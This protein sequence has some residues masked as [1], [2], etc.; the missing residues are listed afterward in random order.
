M[1]DIRPKPDAIKALAE[2]RDDGPVVML[3]LLKFKPAGGAESYAE[4]G[5]KV[6]PFIAALGGRVLYSGRA[7]NVL[8]GAE[9]WDMIALV[10]YPS[11]KAFLAMG[12]DP[13]YQKIHVHREQG[14]ERTVLI[15]TVPMP[16]APG[17]SR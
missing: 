9:S 15:A 14:L 10:E 7:E 6:A 1:S 2:A 4:Y 12:M 13:E 8:I 5:R 16:I 3:N 17:G 11:R